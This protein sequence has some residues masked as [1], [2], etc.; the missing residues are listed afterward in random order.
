MYNAD[1]RCPLKGGLREYEKEDSVIQHL[2]RKVCLFALSLA[3]LLASGQ[4][5]SVS[6]HTHSQLSKLPVQLNAKASLS[7]DPRGMAYFTLRNNGLHAIVTLNGLAPNSVHPAHIHSGTCEQSQEDAILY[8]LP[9]ITADKQGQAYLDTTISGFSI[10]TTALS[11]NIHNGPTLGSATQ[12][13]AIACGDIKFAKAR[14]EVTMGPT[15]YPNEAVSGSAT[16]ALKDRVLTVT[17]SLQG[18]APGSTHAAHI[19]SGSCYRSGPVV[20]P[21]P[22][23]TASAQGTAQVTASFNNVDTIPAYGWYIHVH[24]S[25]DIS[26]QTGY[27]PISCGNIVLG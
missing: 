18:L 15:N 10:P 5:L 7:H 21:F 14:A 1:G 24:D 27:N 16:L 19:H 8:S 23:V 4:T 2:T 3:L 6:A 26:T 12:K 11:L 17:L 25:A 13:V 9:N 20:H 22:V